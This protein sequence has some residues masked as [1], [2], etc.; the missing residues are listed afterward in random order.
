MNTAVCLCLVLLLGA[1]TSCGKKTIYIYILL[2]FTLQSDMY[3]PHHFIVVATVPVTFPINGTGNQPTTFLQIKVLSHREQCF[4]GVTMRL[5]EKNRTLHVLMICSH[6]RVA[7]REATIAAIIARI[8]HCFYLYYTHT[9]LIVWEKKKK[10]KK[11][12]VF[13]ACTCSMNINRFD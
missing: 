11:K 13:I 6:C 3:N 10:K 8:G 1:V 9:D 2:P 4:D 5:T 7:P 12:N